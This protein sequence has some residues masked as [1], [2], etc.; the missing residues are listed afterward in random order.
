MIIKNGLVF[1]KDF[2]FENLDIKIEDGIIKEVVPCGSIAEARGTKEAE[3]VAKTESAVLAENDEVIDAKGLMVIPGLTDIHF[4]GSVGYDFCDG[5]D[6]AI[7]AMAKYERSIGVTNIC[8]AT[9][10]LSRERITKICEVAANHIKTEGEADFV[11]INLEGPFISPSKCGAQNPE[12]VQKADAE[13]IEDLLKV[14]NGLTKLITIA[15]EEEGAVDVIDKLSDKITFS[16]GHTCATYKDAKAAF[17]A[18]AKHVTHLFNAM[19]AFT[20][21]EPGV[22]GAAVDDEKVMAEMICDGIHIHPTSIRT[23]FKMF[24]DDRI[25]LISDSTRACGM[26]DGEYE[27]GGLP[28]FLKDGAVRLKDGTLAG[29][30]TNLFTCMVNVINFGIPKESAIKAAT[31]NPAKAIGILDNYGTIE[32]GKKANIVL[33]NDKFELERVL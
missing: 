14:S 9:M 10:T 16:V 5:S 32:V 19:P 21:R 3:N 23:A 22:I 30:G 24:G 13:M 29:S 4:H 2:K 6:E 11:G 8:P 18:G 33:V 7:T 28:V 27:L 1:T 26:P 20:H 15:P 17:D 31:F 25:I 12:F